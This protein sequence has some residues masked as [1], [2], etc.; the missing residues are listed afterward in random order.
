MLSLYL[1]DADTALESDAEYRIWRFSLLVTNESDH[2]N[3]VVDAECYILYRISGDHVH[4]VAIPVYTSPGEHVVSAAVLN[5]PLRLDGRE[6]KAGVLSFRAPDSTL[7]EHDIVGYLIALSD[8]YGTV[9]R[10][11]PIIV[12]EVIGD[13]E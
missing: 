8:A 11:E 10:A 7:A 3:S 4:N 1:R 6:A 12:K 13:D 9:Y 2:E 5:V